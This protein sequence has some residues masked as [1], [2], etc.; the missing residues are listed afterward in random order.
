M[1]APALEV[2]PSEAAP[3][4]GQPGAPAGPL[5]GFR[6]GITSARKVEELTGLLVRR[7]ARVEWAPAMGIEPTCDATLREATESCVADPPS[8]FVAT[9]G[10]GLRRWFEAAESWGLLDDLV[11]ALG[12]SLVI[13]R[14][15]KSVGALRA[16]GLREAWSPKSECL[17]DVLAY[18]RGSSLAG[19]RI[20]V[21][22]HGTSLSVVANALRR[23][24]A[25]VLVVSVYRCEPPDD[26]DP[27]FRM[28]D[29]VADRLVDAVTFT[30]A[31]AVEILMDVA[32]ASGRRAEVLDA[33]RTD[34]LATCVG[35]VT[36][37]PFEMWGVPV[38][39]PRRARLAAMVKT[40][41]VE[42]PSR[43]TGNE[44]EVRGHRL[45]LHGESVCVD[46]TE[47]SLSPAPLAVLRALADRPG[48]VLSRRDL[49]AHL[50]SGHAGSEH[51]VEVAVARLR[52]AIG[53]RLVQTVVK[54]GYRLPVA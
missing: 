29:L 53:P 12:R 34:V 26:Q 17:E 39:Q 9:T 14:G 50:P 49:M 24:G 20:V 25:E 38:V 32:T 11:A 30:S 10:R 33:F 42:L 35:P 44:I 31:P 27:M 19:R 47:V 18:L 1:S 5:S 45:L 41:E 36:A 6:V 13:A 51:A 28:V 15:P 37:A 23:Q 21:Q 3:G 54:R 7:G 52:A 46:G 48:R 43:R 8:V 16:H 2:P 22:E 40:L 4:P